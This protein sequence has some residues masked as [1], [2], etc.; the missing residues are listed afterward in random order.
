MLMLTVQ[1]TQTTE[2][3]VMYPQAESNRRFGLE[4]AT[5]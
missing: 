1:Q 5:S 2:D 3:V 4:R